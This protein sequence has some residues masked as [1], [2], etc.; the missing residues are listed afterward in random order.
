MNSDYQ[1]MLISW[2]VVAAWIVMV[3]FTN[4]KVHPKALFALFMVELWERFS[5]YGMRP[6][7]SFT[8]RV[9][10]SA[11]L[12]NHPVSEWIKTAVMRSMRLTGHWY[13]SLLFWA[14]FSPIDFLG[15]GNRS[16][17]VQF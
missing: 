14:D 12:K 16:L 11:T 3:I 15:S 10:F 8:S 13:T 2:A 5:Y 1:I 17:R 7:L 9:R 6:S 4:R